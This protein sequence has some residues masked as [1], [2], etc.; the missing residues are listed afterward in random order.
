MLKI[1]RK[2][3]MKFQSLIALALM[4]FANTMLS[5][6]FLTADNG[7]NI[8]RQISVNLC[9]YIG[10]LNNGLFLLNVSPFWQQ[11]VKGFVILAAVAIDRMNQQ[12]R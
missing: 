12:E 3:L 9:L 11:A 10:I 8:L 2:Q 1:N 7:F 4:I 5:D 6:R